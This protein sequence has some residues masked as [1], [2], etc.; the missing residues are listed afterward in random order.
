M[1]LPDRSYANRI[2]TCE[3]RA[4]CAHVYFEALDA[5]QFGGVVVDFERLNLEILRRYKPSGLN[6][7]K[8]QA[9]KRLP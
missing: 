9:W 3:T 2:E 5:A 7:I 6:W 1:N 4:E 8:A